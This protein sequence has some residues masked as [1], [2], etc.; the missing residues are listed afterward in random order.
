MPFFIPNWFIFVPLKY[1]FTGLL[2]LFW[3]SGFGQNGEIKGFVYDVQTGNR[4]SGVYI[5]INIDSRIVVTDADGF[6]NL[7]KL[8]LGNVEITSWGDGYDSSTT[9]MTVTQDAILK[10]DFYLTPISMKVVDITAARKPP[11]IGGI[12]DI[13][14]ETIKKVPAIGAEPDI[15]QYL[16]LLPGVVFSGDQGGQLYIRGGAP[17]MNKV[18]LDGMTIYNPFHSI[19]LFS[20][21]ETDLIQSA[22][23]YTAGFGAQ[24]GGRVSAVVDV[25]TRDGNKT[26]FTGK[27]GATTFTSKVLLEGPLRK[28]K[29][30][31]NNSSFAISY[32]NSYLTQSSKIF[33]N[34]AN[35][36][37]LPYN[38]GDLFAKLSIN[39]AN[40]GYGKLYAFRFG[41]NVNFPNSTS[42]KWN[43]VGFG[44][45][46]LVV[47]DQAKTRVDGYFLYSKYNI[48]QTEN[49]DPD[50]KPRKSGI[51]GFN[52]GM[53]FH[54]NFKRDEF[55]WGIEMNAFQTNFTLYNS[56]NRLIEQQESTTEINSF[57]NYTLK[58]RKLVANIGMRY[59]YYASLSNGSLEPRIQFRFAPFSQFGIKGAAGLY[60]QNLMSAIS[61]KDVVNLF[62][63]FLSGP[64]NLP[65]T[66]NG[67]PV[68]SKLQKA[69]HLVFGFDYSIRKR[70]VFN[71][72]GF[73][74]NF[75]QITNINRDKLFDDDEQNQDKPEKLRQDF[76]IERGNAYGGDISYKYD[77][78]KLYIWAVYS[79]TWVN[80]TDGVTTYQ[81]T[82]DRRHTANFLITYNVDEKNP[83]ELS[84]RWTI[85]SGFPFTQTQGYY[86]KFDFSQGISTNYASGN[87][88]LGIVYAGLNQGRLPWYHRMDVSGKRTWKLKNHREFTAI[89]SIT[90]VYNRANIFYFNRVTLQRVNQLPF[91]PAL[92]CTY[93]F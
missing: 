71:L 60:S 6:Y 68:T 61:D 38:F 44:G 67:E 58:A 36:S 46:F 86:Q 48:T 47:P 87:G 25:K 7:A 57:M 63:G 69:G 92:G 76:I 34:Y 72:E 16:Q 27:V 45:K 35:P 10:Y 89:L 14:A 30:G 11:G 8:P 93:T 1:F 29:A 64:T 32:R 9:K 51:G 74:K 23:A 79:L 53:N 39:S 83:T 5:A 28:F 54:Y 21:F 90:N 4:L 91:M 20:V 31:E 77:H 42:Y 50:P 52:M 19:G 84:L 56:N 62:Y 26:R 22:D 17:I 41:D 37:K 78:K 12:E 66:F 33:Y 49:S 3:N 13:K 40:G 75:T 73:Y 85:G 88:N 43:S 55:K 15:I 70:H 80:R 24:Y 81:P 18:L 65:K 82:F 2:F 59:Q